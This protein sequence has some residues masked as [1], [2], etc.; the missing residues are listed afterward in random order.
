MLCSEKSN[1]KNGNSRFRN[2]WWLSLNQNWSKKDRDVNAPN[3]VA[4]IKR[5]NLVSTWVATEIVKAEKLKDRIQLVKNFIKIAHECKNLSN[6]NAVMEILSGLQNS[7]IYRLKKT[8]EVET[9]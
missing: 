3:I 5:F 8:W 2:H 4:V 1:L 6:Y 9:T 7:A